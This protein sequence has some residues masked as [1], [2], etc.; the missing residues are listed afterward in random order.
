M[1]QVTCDA[2]T[3]R[4]SEIDLAVTENLAALYPEL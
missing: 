2:A 1:L 4:V 3:G